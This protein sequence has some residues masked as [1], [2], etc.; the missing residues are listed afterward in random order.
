LL[1]A[2]CGYSAS[3]SEVSEKIATIAG[4][5]SITRNAMPTNKSTIENLLLRSSCFAVG[6]RMPEERAAW[7]SHSLLFLETGSSIR[8]PS[9]AGL[10]AA[11]SFVKNESLNC[12]LIQA[13]SRFFRRL[14]GRD[15]ARKEDF[16]GG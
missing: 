4:E 3:A 1:D 5:K 8:D 16:A 11:V 7:V 2:G 6:T 12:L 13:A 14:S 10:L 9:K 15:G